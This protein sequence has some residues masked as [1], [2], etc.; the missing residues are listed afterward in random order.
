MLSWTVDTCVGRGCRERRRGG[1]RRR[2]VVV[3]VVVAAAVVVGECERGPGGWNGRE[4]GGM[5]ELLCLDR[6]VI[7]SIQGDGVV[8]LD[9]MQVEETACN[10]PV[11]SLFCGLGEQLGGLQSD[12][13]PNRRSRGA[14]K[15]EGRKERKNKQRGMT[16]GS[17]RRGRDRTREE[18]GVDSNK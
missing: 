1:R 10:P 7:P 16:L 14:R 8:L 3:I 4:C 13:A 18:V 11:S 15:K 17:W 12:G 6:I 2:V 5:A 9:E